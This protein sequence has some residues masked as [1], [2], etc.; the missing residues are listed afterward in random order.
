MVF[1]SRVLGGQ[2]EGMQTVSGT[3]S[4]E[5]RNTYIQFIYSDGT[6]MRTE[7]ISGQSQTQIS[8][9]KNSIMVAL[10]SSS[11]EISGGIEKSGTYYFVTGD[12]SFS[13]A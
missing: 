12:F 3:L 11:V 7:E 4:G 6:Q 9:L 2:S 10:G 13:G 1:M 5:S 8:V